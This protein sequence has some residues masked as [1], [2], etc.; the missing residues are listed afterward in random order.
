LIGFYRFFGKF[1][2]DVP[3]TERSY[4]VEG[5]VSE[6]LASK[7]VPP[8]FIWHLLA[9]QNEFKEVA[10]FIGHLALFLTRTHQSLQSLRRFL[11]SALRLAVR[12][13]LA[14]A[15]RIPVL[16]RLLDSLDRDWRQA[17]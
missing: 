10:L 6:T 7:M 13:W 5:C 11:T 4:C 15:R 12:G 17:S 9:F 2:G 1:K 14:V 8:L 16:S 3:C